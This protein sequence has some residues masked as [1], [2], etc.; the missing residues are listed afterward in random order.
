MSAT[1]HDAGDEHYLA[2]SQSRSRVSGRAARYQV[3]VA[4][5][6]LPL[7]LVTV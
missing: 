2:E 7:R 3:R 6:G 5:H 1:E 4:R